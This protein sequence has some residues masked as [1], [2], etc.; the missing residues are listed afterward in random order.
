MMMAKFFLISIFAVT[1]A[2]PLFAGEDASDAKVPITKAPNTKSPVTKSPVTKAPVTGSPVAN[3]SL[4][5][6]ISSIN[7]V[8][9]DLSKVISHWTGELADTSDIFMGA[10]KLIFITEAGIRSADASESLSPATFNH[11]ATTLLPE[12][13]EDLTYLFQN[14]SAAR[15][16]WQLLYQVNLVYGELV[17]LKHSTGRFLTAVSK[18][19]P[20]NSVE[21]LKNAVAPVKH[22]IT[23][24]V[25]EFEP[26]SDHITNI[27]EEL[28]LSTHKLWDFLE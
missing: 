4:G 5:E 20:A 10:T 8:A 18:K 11:V 9:L 19:V 2:S 26:Q 23:R 27:Q 3:A 12:W 22:L 16:K 1:S 24:V 13:K 21:T 7:T 14:I 25:G 15:P 6:A 17:A 28:D